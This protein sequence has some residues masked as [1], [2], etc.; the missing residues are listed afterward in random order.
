MSG[1]LDVIFISVIMVIIAECIYAYIRYKYK[2]DKSYSL[3]NK[4]KNIL[5]ELPFG[6][7]LF[8]GEGQLLNV[9]DF[10]KEILGFPTQKEIESGFN[11]FDACFF[12]QA[13]KNAILAG[14][15]IPVDKVYTYDNQS[16]SSCVESRVEEK[17]IHCVVEDVRNSKGV[18]ENYILILIDNTYKKKQENKNTDLTN[19]LESLLSHIPV[20]IYIKEVGEKI[21]YIYW[22]KAAEEMSGLSELEVLGKQI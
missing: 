2:I 20:A 4:Y 22:N 6:V 18:I 15:F 14:S 21:R 17:Y 1:L 9:N 7:L 13:D 10:S 16:D 19:L 8:D 11:L 3:Y 12:T 5:T